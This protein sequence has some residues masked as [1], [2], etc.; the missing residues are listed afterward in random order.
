MKTSENPAP[1]NV[2]NTQFETVGEGNPENERVL[3]NQPASAAV[4]TKAGT[5]TRQHQRARKSG[6]SSPANRIISS[7]LVNTVYS[8]CR[9]YLT[10]STASFR[11]FA[12]FAVAN[13]FEGVAQTAAL[14]FSANPI[15]QAGGGVVARTALDA[16]AA[17]HSGNWPG[18]VSSVSHR[19]A[20]VA[21]VETVASL[22]FPRSWAFW[23]QF[24]G[25]FLGLACAREFTCLLVYLGSNTWLSPFS[26]PWHSTTP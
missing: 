15:L 25:G 9:M 16:W 3:M 6:S 5:G 12:T 4:N 13:V 2:E 20:S 19:I 1:A 14:E 26:S 22:L 17:C 18:F 11:D 23:R 10:D 24:T 7:M 21:F 8:G